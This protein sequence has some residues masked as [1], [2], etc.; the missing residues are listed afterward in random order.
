MLDLASFPGL[1]TTQ[2]AKTEGEGL[3]QFITSMTS[4]STIIGRQR[5]GGPS[6]KERA[7][8]LILQFLSQAPESR[9]SA[10]QQTYCSSLV[11]NEEHVCQ[12][13]SFNWGPSPPP[14]LGKA[15]EGGYIRSHTKQATTIWTPPTTGWGNDSHGCGE[16]SQ[17]DRY[18]VIPWKWMPSSLYLS[19]KKCSL[20][21]NS[22]LQ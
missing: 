6:L 1:S 8:G 10:K 16:I 4:V 19:A 2:H 3:V 14:P 20:C 12:R 13:H 22:L 15:W 7:W 18:T 11:Q 5:G 21:I 9:T 17:A